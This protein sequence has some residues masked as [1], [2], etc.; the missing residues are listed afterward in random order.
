MNKITTTILGLAFLLLPMGTLGDEIEEII[1]VGSFELTD[2][3]DVSQDFTIIETVM[4]A[5]AFT[6][7]GYG[8][9]AGFNE[10]G[11][12]TVHTTVFRNGVPANDAG[13]GW[14]DF[15]H[16]L[17]SGLEEV[18]V[19]S[20]PN[21][22]LYG[23]GSLGG[24]VFVNDSLS[25]QAVV[26]LGNEH[27]TLV[28][29][30]VLD[31]LSFTHFDVSN[32]S[33]RTDNSEEDFY[34]NSTA[35]FVK[36]INGIT[37]ATSYTDY[38]YDY[39]NCYTASSSQSNDCMQSGEKVSVSLRNEN[40]TVGYN[41]NNSDYYTEGVST[42]D[43][44][45]ERWYVDAREVFTIGSPTTDLVIGVTANHDKYA[46]FDA[47]DLSAYAMINLDNKLQFGTRVSDDAFIYRGGY[48]SNGFFVNAST[49]YRN[50]TLY[51]LNGDAWVQ[52]NSELDPEEAFGWEVGYLGVTYFNYRF[53]EGIDYDFSLSQYV[54]TGAYDSR[55]LRYMDQYPV[56][57]GSFSVVA[58]YTDTDLPRA[59]KYK[60]RFSYFISVAETQYEL[61]Y[62][63]QFDRQPG[64]YDG[65]FLE[66]VKTV[67]FVVTRDISSRLAVNLTVQDLFNKEIEILPGYGAG[68]RNVFLTLTYR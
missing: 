34:V 51:E 17:V 45:A 11:T 52:P 42:F 68:G 58:G 62:T 28:N 29:V 30:T 14:Y 44:D 36:E 13:S 23:S 46:G 1:V 56:P 12:Q 16:D 55:G 4:P 50:P 65:E 49:S 66:D 60:G 61:V 6:A 43:S 9:F 64:P 10:R 7:G 20:G 33:V 27:H 18:K 37:L 41:S 25:N 2:A 15:G 3:T 8:G 59:P 24:T 67:D 31:S 47:D 53:Q 40:I 38:E 63:A 22:V 35:K 39:D 19:V 54:N 5:M 32:G 57:W 26:R 48:A 21:G